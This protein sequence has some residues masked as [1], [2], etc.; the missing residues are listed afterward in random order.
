MRTFATII[1]LVGI[2]AGGLA[3]ADTTTQPAVAAAPPPA[4]QPAVVTGGKTVII[5]VTGEINDYNRDQLFRHFDEARA[6]GAKTV[7]L[8]L[9]TYGGLVTAGLEIS[10]F[11]KR[12]DDLHTI[13]Y[14]K[15]KAISAG[16]MIAMS[17]DEIVM[18]SSATL[19][20][21][22]PI[23]FSFDGSLDSLPAAERAKQ[24]SPIVSDFLESAARNHHDPLLAEAMVAVQVSVYWIQNKD[25][26]RKFVDKDEYSK[27]K[28]MGWKDVTDAKTPVTV[29]VDS[30]N[31][32]LTVDSDH[33]I[34][35]GLA[36]GPVESAQALADQ[37]GV[38]VLAD[39][40]TTAGEV[41]VEWLGSWPVRLI[42]LIIIFSAGNVIIHAPG[43]GVAEVVG[44]IALALMLGVPLM[45]GYAQWWE[46]LAIFI[47]LGLVSVEILLPGH[48]LPGITGAVLILLGLVMTFVPKEPGGTPGIFPNMHATWWALENGLLVVA[49][50]LV[51]SAGLWVWMNRFLPQIPYFRRLILT[52][53]SGG[54]TNPDRDMDGA[55]DARPLVMGIWPAIGSVGKAV[56]ELKPGGVAEFYDAA[57]AGGRATGVVSESGFIP[58]GSRV[59]VRLV[60][61]S[62]V[63]VQAANG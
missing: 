62:R 48:M 51:C 59:V 6:M 8:D 12:Q 13:A 20:D 16:A 26:E 7:I 5:Q 33:A 37:R 21:C 17:C 60:A 28:L 10:R 25:G 47:G 42:L 38:A 36:T 3:R 56:S 9:D 57:I 44:L 63:V 24:E 53:M 54:G 2:L 58:P 18:S 55:K 52:E 61:G 46:I 31:S 35:F 19:G 1:A 30:E 27:L 49:V 40:H 23:V 22:A 29:P 39:F 50:G 15:D 41:A 14:V 34:L 4:T 45:T 11:I 32:L 43:H